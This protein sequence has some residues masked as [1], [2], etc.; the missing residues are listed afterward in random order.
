MT[1]DTKM[2]TQET[3]KKDY[4]DEIQS[5][6]TINSTTGLLEASG[7]LFNEYDADMPY[8]DLT[9]DPTEEEILKQNALLYK[10]RL[11]LWDSIDK[12][13][14]ERAFLSKLD[15]FLLSSAMLG[16]FI[17]SLN[18]SNVGTAYV[19]GMKEYYQMD[20]NQYNYMHT[21]WTVGYIIGQIPSNLILHR[22]SARFY[23]A[24][25]ELTWAFL[26]LLLVVPTS[27]NGIYALRFLIGLTES[28]YFPGIQYIIGSWYSKKELTKRSTFFACAGSAAGLVSG[29]LQQAILE[30]EWAQFG[31]KPFQWMFVID[32]MVS[33]PVAFYTFFVIPN[34]PSTT[35]AF[36]FS[37]T[38]KRVALER[39]RR[40]GA[41]INTRQPYTFDKIKSFF[42]TWHI[43]TLPVLFLAFNNAG[44]PL[45][46]QSF[47]LWMKNDLKLK[48]F[49]YNIYPTAITAGGIVFSLLVAYITDYSQGRL[50]PFFLFFMFTSVFFS[51]VSLAIWNIPI[52]LHWFAYFGIGI[53]LKIGQPL[54][55]SW[56]NRMLSHDDMK[57]NFVLVVTNTLAYV[58]DAWVPIF[59]FNQTQQPEF[60]IGFC[61]TAGLAVLGLTMTAITL[62]LNVRDEK[63]EIFLN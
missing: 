25:L 20:G 12:H 29:P 61:Y 22:V 6:S 18:A 17:K 27:L 50:N 1:S 15:F 36:Y 2:Y 57:R 14:L 47:Q 43:W 13:P 32:T 11:F 52:K 44:E 9:P 37:E 26:T 5:L 8:I 28:G 10:I 4:L 30:S 63:K 46:Q 54:I 55:F 34:T 39:R 59:T 33:A 24:A 53:P 41:Q 31:L 48:P 60:F 49:Q 19:N 38:D 45:S 58:T 16:Y 51:C 7:S 56:V 21:L 35:N 40:I 3:S 62:H 23:L 42:N